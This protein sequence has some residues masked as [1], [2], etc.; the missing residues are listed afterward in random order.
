[1]L[2]AYQKCRRRKRYSAA[3]AEFEFDGLNNVLHLQRQLSAGIWQPGDYHHFTVTDPKPRLISAA[4]F[5]DRVVHHALVNILEPVFEPRFIFDS[6]ACRRGKGTH[7]AIRRSQQFLRRYPWTL[8]TD[9]VKFFPCIDHEILTARLARVIR[10]K[11]LMALIQQVIDSGRGILDGEVPRFL[12]PGD[13]LFS[14]LRPRGLPIG[15]L[16][17][18]FF[19]NVYLDVVDHFV[20]EDLRAPG[21]VRYADDLVLFGRSRSE[22]WMFRDALQDFL[23]SLRLRLHDR[24]THVAPA[25]RPLNFLGMR[26]SKDEI[27]LQRGAIARFTRK[28][29][30]RQRQLRA[31]KIAFPDIQRSLEAWLAHC[32][33]ANSKGLT[34]ALLKR[35]R[36]RRG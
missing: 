4:P 24:K 16:T 11:Q 26:I 2:L 12:F 36:F 25:E 5:R 28:I 29:R 33:Y 10:D 34:T 9:V 21:Y 13:D 23:V 30:R 31:R 22:M 18:Q 7:R 8:R 32:Q 27:R 1:M 3:A 20:R 17:S 6:Y 14:Q 35:L 15:N 19:A